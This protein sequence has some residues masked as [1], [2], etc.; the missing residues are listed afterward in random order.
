M[1]WRWRQPHCHCL[2][3]VILCSA[4]LKN[5]HQKTLREGKSTHIIW[6]GYGSIRTLTIGGSF[7]LWYRCVL[8]AVPFRDI[9][10][11]FQLLSPCIIYIYIMRLKCDML[12]VL[13]FAA[14]N[15]LFTQ[16]GWLMRLNSKK[17]QTNHDE[18]WPLIIFLPFSFV[19]ICMTCFENEPQCLTMKIKWIVGFWRALLARF[20][21][22]INQKP[23]TY[24]SEQFDSLCGEEN[25][26]EKYRANRVPSQNGNALQN[27]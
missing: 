19:L 16:C 5:T 3:V 20:R 17:K 15:S 26:E 21:N 18:A 9:S 22:W 8:T 6:N 12:G 10:T 7:Y 13:L 11:T 2:V 1:D 4:V 14:H 24:S 23:L 27:L 25:E